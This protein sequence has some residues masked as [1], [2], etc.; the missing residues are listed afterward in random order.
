MQERSWLAQDCAEMSKDDTERVAEH[1]LRL[2]ALAGDPDLD[3]I[4]RGVL[5]SSRVLADARY[6]ALGIPDRRGGFD[7]FLTTGIDEE[8]A[9]RIGELPRRHGVLGLLLQAGE[10]IR[11]ADIRSHPKFV[12]YPA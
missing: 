1:A 12:G 8:A 9:R 5:R 2:L 4:L 10:T 3:E 11:I 6:G 7:R